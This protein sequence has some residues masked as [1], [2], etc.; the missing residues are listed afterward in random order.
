MAYKKKTNCPHCLIE[1]DPK[2]KNH[3]TNHIRWCTAN[4]LRQEYVKKLHESRETSEKLNQFTKAK[5]DGKPIPKHS[6]FGKPGNSN[7]RHTEETKEKIREKALLSKHRRLR[8]K[9]IPYLCKDGST[10][11]LE[12]TWEKELA[13]RLDQLLIEWVRPE[14]IEYIG[15]DNKVHHYFPDF[16]LPDFDLFL[17]P[18]N[19]HAVRVQQP[20]LDVLLMQIKNL[21][22]LKSLTEC[23]TFLPI[24]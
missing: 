6:N 17:D 18:K 16:Y 11:M 10:V 12:S 1:F 4:P 23:K 5:K 20:K 14:P 8:K 7:F 21:V 2:I 9:M 3:A 13:I 22:I 24:A 15:A 19:P